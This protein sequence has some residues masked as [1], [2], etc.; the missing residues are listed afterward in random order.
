MERSIDGEIQ[1]ESE[2][3]RKRVREMAR[4]PTET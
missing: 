4:D 2:R 3:E 1:S